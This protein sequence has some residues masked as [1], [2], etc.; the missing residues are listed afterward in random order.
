MLQHG[1]RSWPNKG[2]PALPDP[3]ELV[4][5]P[6]MLGSDLAHLFDYCCALLGRDAEAT[7]TARSVLNSAQTL[8][9]DK[10]RFLF[11]LT[12]RRALA[13][14]PPSTGEPSYMPEALLVASSQ[15]P[16]NGVLQAFRALTNRDREILDLVYRHR[17]RPANLQDVLGIPIAEVYRRLAVAEEQFVDLADGAEL[18]DI[19]ALPLAALPAWAAQ[20][21]ARRFQGARRLHRRLAPLVTAAVL[22]G[23]AIGAVVYVASAHHAGGSHADPSPGDRSTPAG[24]LSSTPNPAPVVP[25]KTS[26]PPGIP[27]AILLPVPG[28]SGVALPPPLLSSAPPPSSPPPSTPPPSSPPP[29]SPPPSPSI[30]VSPSPLPS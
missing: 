16:D 15:Q 28:R 18:E 23:A 26:P 4:T 12:R 29:S 6:D 3:D 9:P 10:D 17:I 27:I 25:A 21:A 22:S 20:P 1:E 7:S 2:E 5:L 24:Q 14:R 19:A 8:L 30:S 11:A 13:L